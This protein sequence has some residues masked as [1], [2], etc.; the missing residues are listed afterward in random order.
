MAYQKPTLEQWRRLYDLA[1]RLAELDP[2]SFTEPEDM[3]GLVDAE[4]ELTLF[5]HFFYTYWDARH[6]AVYAGDAAVRDFVGNPEALFNYSREGMSGFSGLLLAYTSRSLL[7]ANERQLL[8]ELGRRYRGR[9]NWPCFR[10]YMATA[11][12]RSLDQDEARQMQLVLAQALHILP[13]ARAGEL[14]LATPAQGGIDQKELL[15]CVPQPP[16]AG[17]PS[18]QNTYRPVDLRAGFDEEF[19]EV[20]EA[21]LKQLRELPQE[22]TVFICGLAPVASQQTYYEEWGRRAPDQRLVI[23]DASDPMRWAWQPF[24]PV[25]AFVKHLP[26]SVAALLQDM[27][28]R[29]ARL[30]VECPGGYIIRDKVCAPLGIEY[31]FVEESPELDKLRMQLHLFS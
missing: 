25:A 7:T 15:V 6:M 17:E 26:G 18:W 4:Q 22:D 21:V 29:P 5:A 23:V 16:A 28:A 14:A 2:W 8:R 3:F 31:E 11:Y 27:Q 12:P 30:V 19:E 1:D 20:D 24:L 10:S 9:G 13:A